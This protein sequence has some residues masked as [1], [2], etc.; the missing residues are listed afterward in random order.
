MGESSGVSARDDV[1]DHRTIEV[2]VLG[3]FEFM[4]PDCEAPL[5]QRRSAADTAEVAGVAADVLVCAVC[6]GAFVVRFG[7]VL[8]VPGPVDVGVA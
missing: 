1:D 7:H 4:C 2:Y 3:I 5:D 6:A 8:A